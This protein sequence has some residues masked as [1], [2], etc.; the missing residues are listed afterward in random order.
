MK[1]T[2]P[3]AKPPPG[4]EGSSFLRTQKRLAVPQDDDLSPTMNSYR[5]AAGTGGAKGD[6]FMEHKARTK[7]LS[8][9]LSLAMVLSLLPGMSIPALAEETTG[10]TIAGLGTSA[11]GNPTSTTAEATAWAGSYVYYGKYDGTSPT[12]YRVLDK[13]SNDFGVDGGSLLLDC[14]TSAD[15]KT[16]CGYDIP[17]TVSPVGCGS[18]KFGCIHGF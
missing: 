10:K 15:G 5:I 12:K 1:R 8:W 2:R 18:L 13:A 11:I 17:R 14:D 7:A 3:P 9:L 4:E 6:N 16:T